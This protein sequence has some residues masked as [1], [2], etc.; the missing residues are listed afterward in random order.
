MMDVGGGKNTANCNS[1]AVFFKFS[2]V[3]SVIKVT[4]LLYVIR[5][6]SVFV[7]VRPTPVKFFLL[8]C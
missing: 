5:G 3:N 4:L 6:N 2:P 1:D 8:V 7:I